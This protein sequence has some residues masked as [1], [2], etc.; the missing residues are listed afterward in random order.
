MPWIRMGGNAAVSRA[1]RACG[2]G[3]AAAHRSCGT[4]GRIQGSSVGFRSVLRCKALPEKAGTAMLQEIARNRIR[5]RCGFAKFGCRRIGGGCSCLASI[6][7]DPALL[8][9]AADR[10]PRQ[11]IVQ[12]GLGAGFGAVGAAAAAMAQGTQHRRRQGAVMPGFDF[13]TFCRGQDRRQVR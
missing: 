13:P 6:E 2:C 1:A 8:G 3:Q 7:L 10:G 5:V 12:P 4:V 9:P 11:G